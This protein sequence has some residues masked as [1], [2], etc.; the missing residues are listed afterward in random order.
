MALWPT[1]L[2]NTRKQVN[3]HVWC[4]KYLIGSFHRKIQGL[5][6]CLDQ[7]PPISTATLPTHRLHC[8]ADSELHNLGAKIT[9]NRTRQEIVL[10]T[11]ICSEFENDQHWLLISAMYLTLALCRKKDFTI[12]P[13]TF[14][15]SSHLHPSLP[16]QTWLYMPWTNRG[17][18][19]HG[20]YMLL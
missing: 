19:T 17:Y 9:W 2:H 15:L 12:N 13:S 3:W 10:R 14:I 4:K 20:S 16:P 5:W 6:T 18:F 1:I 11:A 7:R 8:C